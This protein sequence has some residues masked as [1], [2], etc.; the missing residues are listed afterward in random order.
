MGY[1]ITDFLEDILVTCVHWI[2]DESRLLENQILEIDCT[3]HAMN[4]FS[5]CIPTYEM[6]GYGPKIC[7]EDY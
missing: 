3:Y 5:I 2:Y 7:S 4:L 1:K 6:S